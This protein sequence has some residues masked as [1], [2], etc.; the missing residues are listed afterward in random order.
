MPGLAPKLALVADI[1]GTHARFALIAPGGR[2]IVAPLILACADFPGL[3][4]AAEAYLKNSVPNARPRMA[5]FDVA[6]P[7][8]GDVAALTNHPWRIQISAVRQ[9]LDLD[10]LEVINDFAALARAVPRLGPGDRTTI[11]AGAKNAAGPIGVVG[12]GTGLGVAAVIP[13][14]AGGWVP[15]ASE[16]GHVTV[17]AADD[18]EEAILAVLRRRFD[19]VSAERVVSGQGLVNLYEAV[20]TVAG[21]P[22][23]PL[24]PEQVAER[25]RAGDGLPG[26]ALGL[27]FAFLGNVAGNLALTVGAQGGIAIAGGIVPRYI[28]LLAA[29]KFEQRFLGKGRLRAYLEPIPVYVVTHPLPAFIGLAGLL[30][31]V[32]GEPAARKLESAPI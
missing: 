19:H 23:Q 10:R 6:G 9:A 8:I 30:A 24:T 22:A 13:D 18:R 12:P 20:C 29:S 27:F 2:E 11:R 14:G 4:E 7:V 21:Q 32:E 1:G 3:A 17:A 15:L 28:P 16:G 26:E 5:A 31:E 25:A